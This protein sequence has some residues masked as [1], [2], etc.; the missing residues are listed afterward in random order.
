MNKPADITQLL[1][2]WKEGDENASEQL[3][4][5]VEKEL[6]KIARGYMRKENPGHTLQATALVNEAYLKLVD[7]KRVK[8]KNRA[9]FFGI[10]AQCMQRILVDHARA[11]LRQ[12][13]GGDQ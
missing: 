1:D 7:Q 2:A 9:H 3:M 5:L 13:R 10:A 8:W 12:K 6:R 11:K 4:P